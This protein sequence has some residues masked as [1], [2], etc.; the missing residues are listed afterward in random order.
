MQKLVKIYSF[1]RIL[2][3]DVVLGALS[4]GWLAA[5]LLRQYMHWTWWVALPISVWIFYT[6]DHLLDAY[7]LGTSAHTDRHLFHALHFKKILF[8]W[9]LS[10][11]GCIVVLPMFMPVQLIYMGIGVGFLGCLHLG[12]II[13]FKNKVSIWLQKELGV[14]LIYTLGIWLGPVFVHSLPI[15]TE[16]IL[17]AIQFF[18]IA[19]INLL[20]FSL[21]EI[22][23]D[24]KDGHSSWVRAIGINYTKRIIFL[25]VISIFLI[26]SYVL[27]YT[28]YYLYRVV[29]IIIWM[30][31]FGLILILVFSNWFKVDE[32]YRMVGD[33]LFLLPV[34]IPLLV[35]L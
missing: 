21:F 6:G 32:K 31:V 14:G 27:C 26:S 16:Y 10:M 23:T 8:I 11:I 1:L 3:I 7:R 17:I 2:S 15:P 19:M 33:G 30:M 35:Y 22:T 34:F 13:L 18:M 28:D 4:T 12:L 5:T 29:Q 25:F 9:S 24:Q 20:L